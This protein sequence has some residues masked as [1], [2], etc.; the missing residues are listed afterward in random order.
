MVNIG[1]D[2]CA[3][4]RFFRPNVGNVF[5][6][7]DFNGWRTDQLRMVRDAAGYWLLKVWLP[8]GDYKFRYVADGYWY[9]DFAAF[10]VEPGRFGLDSLLHVP[11]QALRLRVAPQERQAGRA[12]AA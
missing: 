8:P 11:Q 4:F 7:G 9:T 10:G 2:G 12:A 5:L 1:E 3:E 6:A